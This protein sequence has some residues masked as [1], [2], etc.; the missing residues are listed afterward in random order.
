MEFL[1]AISGW[2][3]ALAG[4]V[5]A[6]I[7]ALYFLKLRRKPLEVPSTFLWKRSLEDLRVNSLWQ[8][9]R[10][11]VLLWLQLAVAALVIAALLRPAHAVSQTGRRLILL[12]D[13]SASMSA[14]DVAP[15][16]LEAAK[17][18]ALALVEGMQEADAAMVIAFADSA[19]VVASYTQNRAALERAIRSIGSTARATRL[20]EALTIASGL[21]NPQRGGE[22]EAEAVPADLYLFSDGNFPAEPDVSLGNLNLKFVSLGASRENVGIVALAA[23]RNDD[24]PDRLEVFA[25]IRNF[26]AATEKL[27]AELLVNGQSTSLRQFELAGEA[28]LP[29]VFP[30]VGA[31]AAAICV[32]LDHRDH[33]AGDNQAWTALSPPSQIR[34][35]VVGASNSVLKAALATTG[36]GNLAKID[37]APP[38][39]AEQDL[40]DP[41]QAGRY[42]LVIFDRCRPKSMPECNTFF[43]G[44][45][46][47]TEPPLEATPANAPVILNWNA[48]HPVL[49]FLN[50]DDVNVLQTLSVQPP[51]G[52][53]TL[54]ESDK[55]PLLFALRRGIYTDLVQGFALVDDA[56]GWQ[57]DWPLKLSFPLYVM[58]VLRTLGGSDV[59]R[60]L[61]IRP[62][63]PISLAF[64]NDAATASV[65]LPD[66]RKTEVRRSRQGRFELLDTEI[67]GIY[68]VACGDARRQFAVNLFDESESAIAPKTSVQIGAVAAGDTA[69]EIVRRR[70]YW[71]PLAL[72]A[73]LVVLFEWYVYNRRVVI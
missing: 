57:T 62:G 14:D 25:R 23:R 48:G 73:F 58:N 22:N 9:L 59:D 35:L 60:Q 40:A 30:L 21:A 19:R 26:G 69:R 67:P 39:V 65:E 3:W 66:G 34:V 5:P 43:I 61:A 18:K 16:R 28:E 54:I 36:M 15:S 72:A 12:I 45:L 68:T 33:L 2:Q 37:F 24:R 8:R 6:A 47:P 10:H 41:A 13:Q 55:G 50:L 29:I 64:E 53:E 1:Y 11:S 32:R 42:T 38:A 49:R 52:T 4:A 17:E 63:E 56:G 70:E 31:D 46:P 44:A 71:K 27:L 51:A 7:I 20:R